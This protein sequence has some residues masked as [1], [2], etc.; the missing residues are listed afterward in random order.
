MIVLIG[1]LLQFG[2]VVWATLQSKRYLETII[3]K[4][5]A[6]MDLAEICQDEHLR[7]YIFKAIIAGWSKKRHAALVR[8]LSDRTG[9][10][11]QIQNG[12]LLPTNN[13][14]YH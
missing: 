13:T 11:Y 9:V 4:D 5:K 3:A 2:V 12:F 6:L 10:E 14:M 1:T 8:E 7:K